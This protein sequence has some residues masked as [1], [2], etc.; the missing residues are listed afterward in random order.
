MAEPGVVLRENKNTSYEKSDWPIGKIGLVFLGT[1]LLLLVTP[2][3]LMW[4]FPDS[5]HDV[6]RKLTIAPPPPRQQVAPAADLALYLAEQ[7]RKLGTYYWI[8]R[9]RGHRPHPDR[10]GDETRRRAWHSR[11]S[12]G[13]PMRRS[14]AVLLFGA[15]LLG[16]GG[17][18]PALAGRSLSDF[19]FRPHPGAELPLQASLRDEQGRAQPLAAF[20]TGKPVVLVLE[21]LRCRTLCGVTLQRLITA[22]DALPVDA[23]RDY[24]LVAISIDPRDTPADA[25]AAKRKFLAEYRSSGKLARHAFSDRAVGGR[26]PDRRRG[27]VPLRI[28]CDAR[29]V[30][31]SGR[32]HRRDAG[33]A[34]QPLCLRCRSER[35][36]SASGSCRSGTGRT[37]RHCSAG[38]CCCVTPRDFRPAAI[39]CRSS[40]RSRL[41]TLPAP[42]Y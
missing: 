24:H 4:A 3:I 17:A 29:P 39:R 10:R 26:A 22:L 9:D 38:L 8:D 30:H 42:P 27:R 25:A 23:G 40:L 15:C 6:S 14:L 1:F 21:Y 19:A 34:D 5:L 12:E 36:R 11:I 32:V 16:A 33:R 28:R 7:K 41:L 37:A 20:F 2:L 35:Q 13:R 31:S 18:S